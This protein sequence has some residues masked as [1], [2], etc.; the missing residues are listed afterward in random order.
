[1]LKRFFKGTKP[2]QARERIVHVDMFDKPCFMCVCVCVCGCVCVCVCVC[3]V[4][5]SRVQFHITQLKSSKRSFLDNDHAR[6]FND[7]QNVHL[8]AY[9]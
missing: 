5:C 3:A 4:G 9:L 6:D 1:M 7:S 8:Y 2:K